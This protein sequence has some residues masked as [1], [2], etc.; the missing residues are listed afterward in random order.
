MITLT[1]RHVLLRNWVQER[2]GSSFRVAMEMD[3]ALESGADAYEARRVMGNPIRYAEVLYA[4]DAPTLP[5]YRNAR[6]APIQDSVIFQVNVWYERNPKAP[7]KS[8]AAFREIYREG[9]LV[10]AKTLRN[11]AIPSGVVLVSDPVSVAYFDTQPFPN[12]LAHFGSFS[13][14]LI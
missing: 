4:G 12:T 13:L 3:A 5:T 14:T 7:G 2:L 8:E 1:Q 10:P 11:I 9:L 6:G